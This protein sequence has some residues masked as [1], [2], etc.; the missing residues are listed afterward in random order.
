[1]Q[2]NKNKKWFSIL[3]ITLMAM[4]GVVFVWY[5]WG[6]GRELVNYTEIVMLNKEVR[7]G[8]TITEQDLV[9]VKIDKT[10]V[11]DNV[12]TDYTKIVGKEARH[13]IP[14]KSQLH[15]GYFVPQGLVLSEGQVIAQIPVEWTLSVPDTLRRGDDI[16]I[17]SAL[18]DKK[19]LETLQSDRNKEVTTV[20][21]E[22][23]Q[24]ETSEN[25]TEGEEEDTNIDISYSSNTS[26][27]G[28]QEL[29]S[30]KVAYVKDSSNKEVVTVSNNGRLDASSVIQNV[31][32]I[33]TPDE[34]K[35]IEQKINQGGKLI[36][37]YS[38]STE[39]K[40]TDI[41]QKEETV[42]DSEEE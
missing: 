32:I 2:P 15:S 24:G 20:T 1:M 29:L 10:T 31:E 11:I 19:L 40:E 22:T 35:K 16:I 30:T 9:L 26:P 17:Y 25:A 42:S 4:A 3:G 5:E 36:V 23:T 7:E 21:S 6:G 27:E 13:Y 8:Q 18:Y 34:F 41:E 33:T 38:N 14:A 37:M 39:N 28:L 12:V